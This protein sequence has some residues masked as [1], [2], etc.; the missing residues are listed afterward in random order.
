MSIR[1]DRRDIVVGIDGSNTA[2]NAAR[3]AAYLAVA[4]RA[5]LVLANVLTGPYFRS[6]TT[7][8]SRSED[9]GREDY[10]GQSVRIARVLLDQAAE[11]LRTCTPELPVTTE[12][13]HGSAHSALR[14]RTE[15]ARM[16]VVGADTAFGSKLLGATAIHV[17]LHGHCPVGVWRGDAGRPIPRDRTIAVGVDGTALSEPAIGHA[18]ELADALRVPL[19]AVHLWSPA[20]IPPI[21]GYIDRNAEEQA[22]LSESLAGW[23]E[24]F[25]DVE[26][27]PV[28]VPAIPAAFLTEIAHTA[29]LLVI[30]THGRSLLGAALFGSTSRELLQQAPCPVLVCRSEPSAGEDRPR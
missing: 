30:G 7:A 21:G 20:R 19:T 23:S 29:Q 8:L 18:F 3:W 17:A 2:L 9:P 6:E 11:L 12:I 24:R 4:L 22:V 1:A 28:P 10:L 16:L 14:R 27:I 13:L 15:R 5:P 25:P 26:I